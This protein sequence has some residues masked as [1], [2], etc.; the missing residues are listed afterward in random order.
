MHA[1][2]PERRHPLPKSSSAAPVKR[3]LTSLL[4]YAVVLA[5]VVFAAGFG[6]IWLAGPHGGVLPDAAQ[7]WVLACAWLFVLLLPAWVALRVWRR[8][9]C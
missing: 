6:V 4:V 7:P 2:D 9:A 3:M 1:S 5:I 8:R